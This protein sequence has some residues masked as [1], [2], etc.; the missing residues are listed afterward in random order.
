MDE[1]LF[2]TGICHVAVGSN[3]CPQENIQHALD[4]LRKHTPLIG[5][6][7]FYRTAA[8]ARPD[9]PDY[10]NGAVAVQV[11]DRLRHFK[12]DVLRGIEERLGRVR[13]ID[14]YAAR[15]IDLDIAVCGSLVIRDPGM[16]IPDPDI[17]CRPFLAAALLELDPEMILPD[18]QE[19]LS[20]IV[21]RE[22]PGPLN[23]DSAFTAAIKERY[24]P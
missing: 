10:L 12:Y 16:E 20:H 11:A 14:R 9:Q 22:L 3:L 4:L 6:S 17:R 8:I 5:I 13:G 24:L 15:P 2:Y 7:T 23:A 18:T 21:E 19:P 1:R